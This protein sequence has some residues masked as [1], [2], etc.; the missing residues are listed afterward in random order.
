MLD[1]FLLRLPVSFRS[2]NP[3]LSILC[4]VLYVN[5]KTRIDFKVVPTTRI[6]LFK[7]QI[8]KL[9]SQIN[10][11]SQYS[12]SKPILENRESDEYDQFSQASILAVSLQNPRPRLRDVWVIGNWNL[13]IICYLLFGAW[14]LLNSRTLLDL[15]S[16]FKFYYIFVGHKR[17]GMSFLIDNFCFDEQYNSR[18]TI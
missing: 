12:N 3:A 9:K 7:S 18:F 8:T 2:F 10:S 1:S 13:D 5:Y 11:K 16:Q 17:P 4:S 15:K 6:Q 14:D